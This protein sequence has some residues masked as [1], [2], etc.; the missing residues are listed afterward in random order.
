[1]EKKSKLKYADFFKVVNQMRIL[2]RKNNLTIAE[3]ESLKHCETF[4]DQICLLYEN[5]V[6]VEENVSEKGDGSDNTRSM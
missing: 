4:V 1:M 6:R 5:F 2:Q 3:Q